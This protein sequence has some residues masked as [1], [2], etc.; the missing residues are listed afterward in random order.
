MQGDSLIFYLNSSKIFRSSHFFKTN[1]QTNQQSIQRS[2]LF[3]LIP[4]V[5]TADIKCFIVY[6]IHPILKCIQQHLYGMIHSDC[7]RI[8]SEYGSNSTS[9]INPLACR[10][11]ESTFP[12]LIFPGQVSYGGCGNHFSFHHY[13]LQLKTLHMRFA[14]L[15]LLPPQPFAHTPLRSKISRTLKK[16]SKRLGTHQLNINYIVP[17]FLEEIPVS[18]KA[19]YQM[20]IIVFHLCFWYIHSLFTCFSFGFVSFTL[21]TKYIN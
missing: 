18:L 13:I 8:I 10:N 2:S 12:F 17:L 9:Y 4:I 14:L 6:K 16:I 19:F 7:I 3:Q 1:K 21:L 11:S 5:V 20:R 15:M